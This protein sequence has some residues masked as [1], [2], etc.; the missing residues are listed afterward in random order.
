MSY[1]VA[2]IVKFCTSSLSPD[3]TESSPVFTCITARLAAHVS[4]R[5]WGPSTVGGEPS[6]LVI[7][8][9]SP[10]LP[11]LEVVVAVKLKTTMLPM[12][13]AEERPDGTMLDEDAVT[14]TM[15]LPN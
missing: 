8:M 2:L 15:V 11:I 7:G 6:W 14:H 3:T 5:N 1:T 4:E 10:M 13:A 12:V 9:S